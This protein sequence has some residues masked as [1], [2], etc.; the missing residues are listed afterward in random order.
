MD[1]AQLYNAIISVATPDVYGQIQ[2]VVMAR[3]FNTEQLTYYN[4]LIG[5]MKEY[6]PGR[7]IPAIHLEATRRIDLALSPFQVNDTFPVTNG[8]G[9]LNKNGDFIYGPLAGGTIAWKDC[10]GGGFDGASR[11]PVKWASNSEWNHLSVSSIDFP[12]YEYPIARFNKQNKADDRPYAFQVMP[13]DISHLQAIY[14]R[15]PKEVVFGGS[16][17]NGRFIPDASAPGNVNPEWNPLDI[18]YIIGRTL[19]YLGVKLDDEAIKAYGM[20]KE[21]GL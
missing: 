2:P 3:A 17:S 8:Y 19:L 6:Q 9:D 18:N 7:P 13:S 20:A 1:S 11:Y 14:L 10:D 5:N 15:P 4:S 21:G 12:T 16:V